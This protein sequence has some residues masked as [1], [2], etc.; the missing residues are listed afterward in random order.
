VTASEVIAVLSRNADAA[1]TLIGRAAPGLR[2]R[3]ERCPAGCDH[4]LDGAILTAPDARDPALT[5][6][7]DAIAGRVLRAP[8]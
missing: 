8:R 5:A 7:L 2:T 1:R 3:P 4:A 6:R